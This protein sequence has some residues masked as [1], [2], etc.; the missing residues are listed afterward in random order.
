MIPQIE[1]VALVSGPAEPPGKYVRISEP[2]S[3]CVHLADLQYV[4]ALASC[5][6]RHGQQRSLQGI[7]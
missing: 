4:M 5:P 3:S 7:L 2:F 1:F 6:A